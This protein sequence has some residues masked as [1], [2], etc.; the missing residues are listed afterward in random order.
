MFIPNTD[1][2]LDSLWSLHNRISIDSPRP[3]DFAMSWRPPWELKRNHLKNHFTKHILKKHEHLKKPKLIVQECKLKNGKHEISNGN[4]LCF[5][6]T[7]L[8]KQ[9]SWI[10]FST[11][12]NGK[13]VQ[14]KIHYH[15]AIYAITV[16]STLFF[17]P[18]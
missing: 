18:A 12:T 13:P 11:W 15:I 1:V 6:Q 4:K 10:T 2:L 3:N 5:F 17:R 14:K 8:A 16:F 9:A 7:Y